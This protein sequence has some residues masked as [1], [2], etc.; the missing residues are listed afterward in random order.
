MS[1]FEKI[2]ERLLAKRIRSFLNKYKVLYELQ[3]G[4]REGHSTTHALLELLD[5]V[6]HNLDD[7]NSCIGVF[8]D[9]SKAF[10]TIQ[11]DI[12]LE[13]LH[14]YGF[15]GKIHTWFSSY[16]KHRKQYTCVNSKISK[17]E[18]ISTGVPQGSVLGPILFTLYVNDMPHAVSAKPRLFADDTCIFTFDKS[19]SALTS[20]LNG[21]LRLLFEWLAANKLLVNTSKTNYCIFAPSKNTIIPNIKI[22]M[23]VELTRAHDIKYLGRKIDDKLSWDSHV[24]K[25]KSEIIKYSAIF[26]KLRHSIPKECLFDTI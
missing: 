25:V 26:A 14:N 6:Y 18:E 15:R 8:L 20:T 7:N 1:C 13:K 21:E 2:L 9:L 5:N 16:L 12:L 23:S 11:H 24:N 4:F 3:F 19:I 22:E 17:T 10:D